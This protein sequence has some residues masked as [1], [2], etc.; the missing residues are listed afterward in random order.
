MWQAPNLS[1]HGEHGGQAP[2]L[3][4]GHCALPF[5]L[6]QHASLQKDDG[7]VTVQV[8]AEV[9]LRKNASCNRVTYPWQCDTSHVTQVRS[10][11]TIAKAR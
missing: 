9:C 11:V 1:Q 4:Q 8:P 7:A 2:N 6:C 3:S 5:S 10:L